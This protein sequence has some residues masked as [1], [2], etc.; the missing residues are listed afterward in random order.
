MSLRTK[1]L[2]SRRS[3]KQHFWQHHVRRQARGKLTQRAY[4]ERHGLGYASFARWRQLL[5]ARL[6]TDV[7][8]ESPSAFI[9]VQIEIPDRLTGTTIDAEASGICLV[10]PGGMRIEGITSGNIDLAAGLASRL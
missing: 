2:P 7:P 1:Q 10:L 4:C 5:C 8:A 3:D 9:P 6:Q